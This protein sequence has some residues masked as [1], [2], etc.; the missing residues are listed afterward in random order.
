MRLFIA[1]PVTRRCREQIWG[2]SQRLQKWDPRPDGK[3]R[4]NSI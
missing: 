2:L 1:L 3:G 4:K